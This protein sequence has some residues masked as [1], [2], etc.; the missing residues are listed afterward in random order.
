MRSCGFY[1]H[2]FGNRDRFRYPCLQTLKDPR[3]QP[4]VHIGSIFS[5][6]TILSFPRAL[7][8]QTDRWFVA[9]ANTIIA[10]YEGVSNIEILSVWSEGQLAERIAHC[11]QSWLILAAPASL[12]NTWPEF[13]WLEE[14]WQVYITLHDGFR[15]FAINAKTS[16]CFKPRNKDQKLTPISLLSHY[17][18]SL[19]CS[20]IAVLSSFQKNT[21]KIVSCASP[22]FFCRII[23]NFY[24]DQL[25]FYDNAHRHF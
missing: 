23:V 15:P 4:I 18:A 20:A 5:N 16:T 19:V 24:V 22:R 10:I 14:Q 6:K 25:C 9:W 17:E 8:S 1:P 7:R 13:C 2:R 11:D 21:S 3:E 12:F